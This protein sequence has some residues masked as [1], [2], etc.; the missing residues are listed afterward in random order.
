L[1]EVLDLG[2]LGEIPPGVILADDFGGAASV[3]GAITHNR[4]AGYVIAI[5]YGAASMAFLIDHAAGAGGDVV[6]AGV[7]GAVESCFGVDDKSDALAELEGARE[8]GVVCAIGLEFDG[9]AFGTL[10]HGLL[11]ALGIGLSLVGF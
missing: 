6:V 9:L 8:E 11:D 4:G 3:D 2:F 10:V 7:A 1:V 5:D